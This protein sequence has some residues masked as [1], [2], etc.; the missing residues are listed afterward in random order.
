M[1]LC[2]WQRFSQ[3]LADAALFSVFSLLRHWC[4]TQ[5]L[6][7]EQFWVLLRVLEELEFLFLRV[8]LSSFLSVCLRGGERLYL[9]Q[10]LAVD[11]FGRITPSA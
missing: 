10:D 3:A 11:L 1:L 5:A 2:P 7:E 8:L 4:S 9:L 6:A